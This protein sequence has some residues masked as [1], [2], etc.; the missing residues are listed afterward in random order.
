MRNRKR[1]LP[2]LGLL[3]VVLVFSGTT[4]QA[5]GVFQCRAAPSCSYALFTCAQSQSPATVTYLGICFDEYGYFWD[6]NYVSCSSFSE[7]CA[8]YW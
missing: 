6:Y 2:A 4:A 7:N 5:L 3:I 8:D 1:H